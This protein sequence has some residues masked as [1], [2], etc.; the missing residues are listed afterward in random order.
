MLIFLDTR[1]LIQILER[2]RPCDVG[3]LAGKLRSGKHRL[4]VSVAEIMELSAPLER[5]DGTGN[6]VMRTLTELEKLPLTYIAENR[7]ENVAEDD[8]SSPADTLVNAALGHVQDDLTVAVA[9]EVGIPVSCFHE[10]P[11]L[12]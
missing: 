3:T 11:I 1:D 10:D 8:E 4:C 6:S 2:D 12:R 9:K 7:L 5:G